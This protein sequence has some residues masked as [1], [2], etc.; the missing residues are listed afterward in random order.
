MAAHITINNPIFDKAHLPEFI[1]D[2]L[3]E[4]VKHFDIRVDENGFVT[5]K[6]SPADVVT[7]GYQLLAWT[8]LSNR[9]ELQKLIEEQFHEQTHDGHVHQNVIDTV[10]DNPVVTLDQI[11]STTYIHEHHEE[12]DHT[13]HNHT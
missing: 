9:Q 1:E 5:G 13:G 2:H 3:Q 11:D 12:Q 4:F 7:L 8:V 10:T 6:V